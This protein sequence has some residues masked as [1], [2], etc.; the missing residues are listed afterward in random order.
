ML[1]RER[2]IQRV[3]LVIYSDEG[4]VEYDIPDP[5]EV[6]VVTNYKS[7]KYEEYTS[8]WSSDPVRI[9]RNP[10]HLESMNVTIRF[11]NPEPDPNYKSFTMYVQNNEEM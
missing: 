8:V 11:R 2:N 1:G 10:G 3:S 5:D 6:D 4:Y 9:L 7:P